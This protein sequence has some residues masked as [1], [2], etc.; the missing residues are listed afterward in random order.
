MSERRAGTVY[1]RLAAGRIHT[2]TGQCDAEDETSSLT[3]A[4]FTFP[5]EQSFD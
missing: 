4:L 5:L 2:A 3:R 1:V